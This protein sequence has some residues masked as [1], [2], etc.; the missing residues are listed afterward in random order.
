MKYHMNTVCRLL[1]EHGASVS[2]VGDSRYYSCVSA[3]SLSHAADAIGPQGG[4][5]GPVQGRRSTSDPPQPAGKRF[6]FAC[7]LIQWDGVTWVVDASQRPSSSHSFPSVQHQKQPCKHGS[8]VTPCPL[9]PIS[10]C[11][12]VQHRAARLKGSLLRPARIP[13]AAR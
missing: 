2:Y 12:L 13:A 7:M 5:G 6:S 4:L 3:D 10:T 11:V 9:T 8:R 1:V